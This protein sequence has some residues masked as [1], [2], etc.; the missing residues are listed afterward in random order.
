MSRKKRIT[1]E[2]KVKAV[3]SHL[4]DGVRVTEIAKVL[5]VNRGTVYGWL[6]KYKK[7]GDYESL[8]FQFAGG[9]KPKIHGG[10]EEK[11]IEMLLKPATE[12]GFEDPL[13]TTKRIMIFVQKKF[14]I[15]ISR[16][17]A[18]R[19]VVRNNLRY[20]SVEKNYKEGSKKELEDWL[21][22][23]L[24]R[25]KE[26][27]RKK[28]AMLYFMDESNL[29]LSSARGKTWA[30]VG[31]RPVVQVSGKRGSVAAISA[32]SKGGYLAFQLHDGRIKTDEVIGFL[33]NLLKHHRKRRL[34]VF[35]DN[36]PVHTA[37]RIKEFAEKND[38]LFIEF[39]P[40]YWPKYNPDEYI[41]NYLKNNK[42]Q[43]YTA[44]DK[45]ELKKKPIQN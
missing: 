45:E 12:Y 16:M 18:W 38:R 40:K 42:M 34:L 44:T 4:E 5:G 14:G 29:Q 3:K 15:S 35:M 20:K 10:I 8:R 32:I 39:L 22:N 6:K 17:T 24:P 21:N 31:I 28:Q 41:W 7:T 11:L 9:P 27:A 13:W 23:E 26:F 2:A 36:A 33:D 37:K 25:I 19:T 30:P 43:V 1:F